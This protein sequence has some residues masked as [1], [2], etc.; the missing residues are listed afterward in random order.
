MTNRQKTY[1]FLHMT[2]WTTQLLLSASLIWAA[3]LKLFQPVEQLSVMWPWTAEVSA[4]LLTFTGIVDLLGGLG[5]L[6][7]SLLRIKPVLTPVAAVAI[8]VQMI[9]AGVFHLGRSE[10]ILPNIVFALMAAFIAWGRW[11]GAPIQPK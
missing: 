9:G 6:L 3:A 5:I 7:P 11:K 4:V 10:E 2:L 1:R 8:V